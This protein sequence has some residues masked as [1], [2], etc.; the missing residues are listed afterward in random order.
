LRYRFNAMRKW[1]RVH[2]TLGALGMGG[3][4]N[5]VFQPCKISYLPNT[6]CLGSIDGLWRSEG[7]FR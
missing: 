7:R 2:F 3:K 5:G 4:C 6:Q 1:S